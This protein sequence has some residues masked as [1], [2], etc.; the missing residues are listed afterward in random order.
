MKLRIITENDYEDLDTE[1]QFGNE[2]AYIRI[3]EKPGEWQERISELVRLLD[4]NQ[5]GHDDPGFYYS[6]EVIKAE[7]HLDSLAD[8]ER[9]DEL[10]RSWRNPDWAQS[11]VGYAVYVRELGTPPPI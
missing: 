11:G 9:V 8:Y 4:E 1:D 2:F 3:I 5:I 6:G 7:I 10:L